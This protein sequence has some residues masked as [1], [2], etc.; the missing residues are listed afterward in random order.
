MDRGA[1]WAAVQGVAQSQTR[2]KRLSTQHART[3]TRSETATRER[4]R[5]TDKE[6]KVARLCRD[7]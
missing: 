2:L 6:G 1:W 3:Q 7:G 5:E 4:A